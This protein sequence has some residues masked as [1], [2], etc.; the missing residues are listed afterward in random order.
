[1]TQCQN[2]SK[3]PKCSRS[4][5]MRDK[6]KTFKHDHLQT[7]PCKCMTAGTMPIAKGDVSEPLSGIVYKVEHD[8]VIGRIASVRLFNGSIK[9][10]DNIFI[11]TQNKNEKISQI[12]KLLGQKYE[13]IGEL[14]PGRGGGH[15]IQAGNRACPENTYPSYHCHGLCSVRGRVDGIY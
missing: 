9:N 2:P 15:I 8:N 6:K 7:S 5:E 4:Q 12:R 14:H 13:D 3:R 11:A 10:R 1:M